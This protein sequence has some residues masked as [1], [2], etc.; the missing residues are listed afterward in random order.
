[1]FK[2]TQIT[3]SPRDHF[4]RAVEDEFSKF[5]RK[6][7]AFRQAERA[8]RAANLRLPISTDHSLAAPK[9]ARSACSADPRLVEQ[10]PAKDEDHARSANHSQG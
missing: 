9:K 6:E 1:M 7:R 2:P 4:M 3:R 5:E 8:E 10:H